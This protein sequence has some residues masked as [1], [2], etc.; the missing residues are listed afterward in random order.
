MFYFVRSGTADHSFRWTG[1]VHVEKTA[2]PQTFGQVSFVSGFG[3]GHQQAA[4]DEQFGVRRYQVQIA[5]HGVA[6]NAGEY[7]VVRGRFGVCKAK[8]TL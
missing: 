5:R 1:S 7:G 4:G 8:E 3:L 6:D 2:H